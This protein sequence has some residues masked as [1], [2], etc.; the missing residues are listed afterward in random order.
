MSAF[1]SI[2]Q[3]S[4]IAGACL[5]LA[6]CAGA[7]PGGGTATSARLD[8]GITSSNGGGQRATGNTPNIGTSNMGAVQTPVNNTKGA[9]Y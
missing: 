7:E 3:V 5:A 6:A 1:R 8:S 9:A 2:K 4:I